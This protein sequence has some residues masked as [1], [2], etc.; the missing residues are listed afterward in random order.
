M[1]ALK[2]KITLNLMFVGS[3]ILL[4]GFSFGQQTPSQRYQPVRDGAFQHSP[5]SVHVPPQHLQKLAPVFTGKSLNSPPASTGARYTFTDQND[6]GANRLRTA[7]RPDFEQ[8]NPNSSPRG[9]SMGMVQQTS[10]E[11]GVDGDPVVPAILAGSDEDTK[12]QQF[13]PSGPPVVEEVARKTVDDFAA[14]M[15]Q[16]RT[17]EPRIAPGEL[18]IQQENISAQMAELRRRAEEKVRTDAIESEAAAEQLQIERLDAEKLKIQQLHDQQAAVAKAEADQ[19]AIQQR[20]TEQAAAETEISASEFI[21]Q[22][23][24]DQPAANAVHSADAPSQ[25]SNT[26]PKLVAKQT[27]GVPAVMQLAK[28]NFVAQPVHDPLVIPVSSEETSTSPAISLGSPALEVETFGPQTVGINKPAKYQVVVHNNS[29]TEADRILVGINIPQWVDI[30]NVNL[31][32]GGKEITD[33][34]KQARLVWSIDKIP[35]HSKQTITITAVPRKAEVFD[36]GVEW[37]LV[38]RVGKTNINVTEPKLEMSIAG[39][40]EVLYGETALYHVTVRNPGTGA[41]ENVI[42]MLPEALGGERAT[43]GSIEA[44][45][46]KNFQVELLARTAGDLNLVA[47]AAADGNLKTSAERALTVRRASLAISLGGPGLKYAGS[48]AEYEVKIT[49][50]GDA[51]ANDVVTAVALPTGVKYLGGIETV[52]L[53]E[54]GMRWPVGSLDPG[55]T[56][57][58]KISCQLDT[59]GDLQLEVGARGKGDLA[60]SSACL[61]TV[62]TVADLVLTVADPKGPLPTGEQIPYEIKVQNRGTKSAKGVNLVMQFSE[63]IEPKGATGIESRIVPGQVLFSPISQIEPGQEISVIV[64]AEAMKSGTHVFRA[65]L[66]CQDSDAREIAEGTT[67]FFGETVQS[68]ATANAAD[69]PSE[70]GTND[71]GS[72]FQR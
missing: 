5:P 27:S 53:I 49:N 66:T 42:V 12:T 64:T 16:V 17:S 26:S 60:A 11:L 13:V 45:K 3:L 33:G 7:A 20:E 28:D 55:Q 72:E 4:S 35:G 48:I 37:T 22:I 34:Q 59:S 41:A 57:T 30:E 36:V 31:T 61:T 51:R 69:A 38:P 43:L 6:R 32:T 29:S 19:R 10:F 65:Q 63:G 23:A 46:E 2:S 8:T 9:R 14:A 40:P 18:A 47:T 39:P 1:L 62:E 67:R 15:S 70:T 24:S 52:K 68:A 54:G 21:G 58:Y 25:D 50:N 56:R 71:F 44:G